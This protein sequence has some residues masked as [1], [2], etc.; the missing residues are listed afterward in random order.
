MDKAQIE[1]L[2]DVAIMA[3]RHWLDEASELRAARS[4]MKAS[5][6]DKKAEAAIELAYFVDAA[7]DTPESLDMAHAA[8]L[9]E[10]AA[11]EETPWFSSSLLP[12]FSS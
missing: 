2:Y 6:A 11:I 5:L 12:K 9:V 1:R 4:Y 8:S 10:A 3:E 7:W